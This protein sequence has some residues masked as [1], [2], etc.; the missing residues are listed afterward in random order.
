VHSLHSARQGLMLSEA[1]LHTSTLCLVKH[2][3][4]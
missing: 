3:V 4:R 2:L 1:T